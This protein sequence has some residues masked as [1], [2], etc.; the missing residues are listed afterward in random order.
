MS[1]HLCDKL[2]V[3]VGFERLGADFGPV[4]GILD[5]AEGQFWQRSPWW[6][7]ETIL[8]STSRQ[9]SAMVFADFV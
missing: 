6:L 1:R 3:E 2:R 5:P 9:T 8:L 4:A 7:T